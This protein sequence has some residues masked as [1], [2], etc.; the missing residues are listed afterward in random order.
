MQCDDR[1]LRRVVQLSIRRLTIA[2]QLH[3]SVGYARNNHVDRLF[4][5]AKE[6]RFLQ[7]TAGPPHTDRDAPSGFQSVHMPSAPF[8]RERWQEGDGPLCRL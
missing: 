5:A 7:C 3:L 1:P 4:G 2:A 8:R 6:D